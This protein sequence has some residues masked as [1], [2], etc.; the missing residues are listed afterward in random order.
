[1]GS[2]N[3]GQAESRAWCGMSY[4]G[5]GHGFKS[6]EKRHFFDMSVTNEIKPTSCLVTVSVKG[7]W[8]WSQY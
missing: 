8:K 2:E 7:E 6:W 1:M 4:K 5:L 3:A